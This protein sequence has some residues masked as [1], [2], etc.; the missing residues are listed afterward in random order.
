MALAPAKFSWAMGQKIAGNPIEF[1]VQALV[2][3]ATV[4]VALPTD[5]TDF[6]PPKWI[7]ADKAGTATVVD[8]A[9]NSLAGFP[10]TGLE[11]HIAVREISALY[12]TT[13]VFGGY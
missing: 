7:I 12:T 6:D 3:P 9:G 13:K 8:A 5:G 2:A 4:L 10:L 1:D 11:Q